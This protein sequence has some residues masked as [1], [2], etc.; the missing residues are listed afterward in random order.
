[1]DTNNLNKEIQIKKQIR[2]LETNGEKKAK[3]TKD[4]Q[5]LELQL[6]IKKLKR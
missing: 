6:K 1:M 3:L 4:I 5:K 2:N